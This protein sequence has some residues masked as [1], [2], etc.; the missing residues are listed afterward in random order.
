MPTST[1]KVIS[2]GV[3][4]RHR[5]QAAEPQFPPGI[6][7]PPADVV[8]DPQALAH[9]NRFA[10]ITHDAAVL[11]VA[12][13]DAL[14]MLAHVAA[15]LE[16]MRTQLTAMNHQALVVDELRDPTSGVVVRRRI[17]ENPLH[18]RA[19][20]LAHLLVK[21]LELFGLTP[22]SAPR[23][24]ASPTAPDAFEDFLVAKRPR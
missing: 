1:L 23:V 19:E 9:W 20:K 14:A 4:A 15:D 2:G 21:G 12:H 18:R 17:K 24:A 13:A 22:T 5:R 11:S 8:A 7:S 10:T 3:R 16:R 6:P